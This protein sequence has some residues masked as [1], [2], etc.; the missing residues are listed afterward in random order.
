MTQNKPKLAASV[1]KRYEDL[2]FGRALRKLRETAGLSQVA[3]AE[4]AGL[5][6]NYPSC[7]ERGRKSATLSIVN[8]L[9]AA[10]KRQPSELIA[11]ASSEFALLEAG[12]TSAQAPFNNDPLHPHPA[13]EAFQTDVPAKA[14]PLC[15]PSGWD[16]TPKEARRRGRFTS[17]G[18]YLT[19]AE[20]IERVARQ[21]KKL[22]K[23]SSDLVISTNV[24]NIEKSK[25]RLGLVGARDPGVAVYWREGDNTRCM[26]IDRYG[27]LVCNIAAISA[28]LSAMRAIERHGG[29]AILDRAFSGFLALPAPERELWFEVLGVRADAGPD[30]IRLAHRRLFAANPEFRTGG[31]ASE[32]ARITKARDEGLSSIALDHGSN[33]DE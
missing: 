27:E 20:A 28:S 17:Y 33:F 4:A 12:V 32:L 1:R 9:A 19:A 24:I 21:L 11:L 29:G 23:G 2:A 26:A 22:R 6:S 3:L 25:D 13:G 18:L 7:L 14:Y 30:E 5:Y 16:R 10:L 8:R 15:W 31:A